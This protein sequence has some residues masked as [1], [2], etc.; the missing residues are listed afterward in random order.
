MKLSS[1]QILAVMVL[2]L[3]AGCLG[4]FAANTWAGEP[5]NP[6]LH[7]FVHDE[8]TLDQSQRDR[9]DAL[10]SKFAVERKALELALRSANARLAGAMDEEHTYG[11]KVSAAID[12]VHARM[13]DLQKATVR[14]VFAMRDILDAEQQR[15]FDQQINR[16]LTGSPSE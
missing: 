4:A 13:G 1:P 12:E 10:E 14:H 8:M 3:L 15:E 16:S 2:A 11:P 9:L 7:D 5:P 6:G